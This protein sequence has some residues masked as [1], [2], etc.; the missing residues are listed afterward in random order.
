MKGKGN[1]K[2]KGNL[3]GKAGKAGKGMK[4]GQGADAY[5]ALDGGVV[6]IE[7]EGGIQAMEMVG[8]EVGKEVKQGDEGEGDEG[9]GEADEENMNPFSSGY[10][11]NLKERKEENKESN[12]E[13]LFPAPYKVTP[14]NPNPPSIKGLHLLGIQTTSRAIILQFGRGEKENKEEL[15]LRLSYLTHTSIQ[16]LKKQ[17]WI[18]S[19]STVPK[20]PTWRLTFEELRETK[21]D[22][23]HQYNRF[24]EN[25]VTWMRLHSPRPQLA[26]KAVRDANQV[27]LGVGVYTVS[28]IFYMAGLSPFLTEEEVFDSPSRT[29]RLCEALWAYNYKSHTDLRPLLRKSL[30]DGILAPTEEQRLAYKDWL[31]VYGKARSR[32]TPRLSDLVQQYSRE[33]KRLGCSDQDWFRLGDTQILCLLDDSTHLSAGHYDT[34]FSEC[35]SDEPPK[36]FWR[37]CTT[38]TY[39]ADKQIWSVVPNFPPNSQISVKTP[40]SKASIRQ[41]LDKER[42]EAMFEYIVIKTSHGKKRSSFPFSLA[43]AGPYDPQLPI[44]DVTRNVRSAF[45]RKEKLAEPGKAKTAMSQKQRQKL[46]NEIEQATREYHNRHSHVLMAVKV[47]N[48][49]AEDPDSDSDDATL[50]PSSDLTYATSDYP[51]SLFAPSSPCS[52]P[53]DLRHE[54]E[55]NPRPTTKRPHLSTIDKPRP[56]KRPR[57]AIDKQLALSMA[58]GHD[59]NNFGVMGKK[60]DWD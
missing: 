57:L 54:E 31:H 46:T 9:E 22:V 47:N 26:C 24:L 18:A 50:I 2:G 30:V 42:E 60:Y 49:V 25:V 6:E 39:T 58:T 15:W 13:P 23:Y 3:K 29:A 32:V 20:K 34:L 17:D 33:L 41:F 37:Y 5:E 45:R 7:V 21:P 4:K 11:K 27:W 59:E 55:N 51:S 1:S 28:E 8:E 14:D 40:L 56:T 36:T 48:T 53:P 44:Q 43:V 35:P 12:R 10:K 16:I 52:N 19:V 38:Y